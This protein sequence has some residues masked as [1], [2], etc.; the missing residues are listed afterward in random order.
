LLV[1]RAVGDPALPIRRRQLMLS[2]P[3]VFGCAFRSIF[4]RADVQRICVIDS[5]MSAVAI[6]RTVA[7]RQLVRASRLSTQSAN[8]EK[9]PAPILRWSFSF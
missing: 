6:G 2:A 8:G 4:P 9:I 7:N 1:R 5:W 3:F